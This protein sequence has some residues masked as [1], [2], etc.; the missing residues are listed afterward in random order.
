MQK[1]MK[2]QAVITTCLGQLRASRHLVEIKEEKKSKEFS[3]DIYLKHKI[4]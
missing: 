2:A 4:Q 1:I 3:G